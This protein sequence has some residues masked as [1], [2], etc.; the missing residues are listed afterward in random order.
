MKHVNIKNLIL[1]AIS[2]FVF[3]LIT[4]IFLANMA[5]NPIL[6]KFPNQKKI[7]SF[8]PQGW[9]FFTRSPREAQIL[10][11][12]IENNEIKHLEISRHSSPANYFGLNRQQTYKMNELQFIIDQF[13]PED[14]ITT[15][16]N[17]LGNIQGQIPNKLHKVSSVF[18]HSLLKN[19]EIVLVMQ[20]IVPW[21]WCSNINLKMPAKAIRIKI[22]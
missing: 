7:L 16:W 18:K 6:Y 22:L 14:Y 11:Y 19:K 3:A 20:E 13:E 5:F 9:A 1:T 17:Y 10:V 4:T 8:I 2:L 12:K 21:A 15:Y